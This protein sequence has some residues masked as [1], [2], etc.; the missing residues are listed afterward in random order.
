MGGCKYLEA[1]NSQRQKYNPYQF[2]RPKVNRVDISNVHDEKKE[3]DYENRD[4]VD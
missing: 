1:E 2:V 3:D 4:R